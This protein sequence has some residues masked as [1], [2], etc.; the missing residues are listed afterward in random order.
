MGKFLAGV[1]RSD[2]TPKL[3]CKMMGYG[4][5]TSGAQGVHDR[6]QARALVLEDDGGAVALVSCDLCYI[7]VERIAEIRQA[8]QTRTGIAPERV[9]IGTTHT[10]SGPHDGHADNWDRPFAEIVADAVEQAYQSRRPARVG[11]GYGFL[12]GYSINRRWLDRPVDPGITALRVDD[13]NGK[14]IGLV[15]VFGDHAVVM[16]SDNLQLS[17]DWPGY[18]MA[19]LEQQLGP[20]VVSLFFQGGAGDINPLVSGVRKHLRAGH[21]I[22][23]IGE[24]SH[25]YGQKDDPLIWNIGDRARGSFEEVAE[26]GAAYAEEVGYLAGTIRT[27]V[28]DQPLWTEQVTVNA[29]ADPGEHP[30]RKP[31]ALIDE[32]PT[33]TDERNIPAEIMIVKIGDLVLVGQPGEVFSETAVNLRVRLR[34]MG[35]PSPALVSYANGWFLYLPEP[36]AFVEGGYEPGWAVT[37]GL[38][39]QFQPRVWA[40]IEPVLR[41]RAP[42]PSS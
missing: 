41:R 3:G 38:S 22:R 16:G 35:Y 11:T 15:S 29:A 36:G 2:I 31:P 18:A 34:M 37:C 33:I 6:L 13:E 17:G 4:G 14:L 10:H 40:A 19:S 9:F 39:K 7:F 12:Y 30:V 5:R 24:V 26:L 21:A 1:G 27:R 32:Y 20:G 28:P 42:A 8:V 23:A 25:Y